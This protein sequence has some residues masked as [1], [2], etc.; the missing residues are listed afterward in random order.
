M[1]KFTK[2]KLLPPSPVVN[3]GAL[4]QEI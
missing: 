1:E 3:I 4:P 2:T